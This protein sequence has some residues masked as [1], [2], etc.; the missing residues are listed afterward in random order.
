MKMSKTSGAVFAAAAATLLIAGVV[1]APRT[2]EAAAKVQCLGVNSCKG[3]SACKSGD[4]A[5]KGQ[6]SCKGQG[7][8]ELSKAQCK[9]KGGKIG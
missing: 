8:L 1:G 4:H 6:N 5:C 7:F 3:T 2:A 9:A